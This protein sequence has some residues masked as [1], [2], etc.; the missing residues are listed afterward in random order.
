MFHDLTVNFVIPL[1]YS[2][3]CISFGVWVLS[4]LF[5]LLALQLSRSLSIELHYSYMN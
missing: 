1:D 3:S 5:C 2:L 4:L